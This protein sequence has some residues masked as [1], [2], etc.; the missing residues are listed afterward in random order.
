MLRSLWDF[1]VELWKE[2]DTRL[3]D[4]PGSENPSNDPEIEIA[5]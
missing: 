1:I 3:E 5:S 4:L 2:L